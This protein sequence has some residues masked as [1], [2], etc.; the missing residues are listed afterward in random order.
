MEEAEEIRDDGQVDELFSYEEVVDGFVERV[1]GSRSGQ[2]GSGEVQSRRGGEAGAAGGA[3]EGVGGRRQAA[4]E[5]ADVVRQE[6]LVVL[7]ASGTEIVLVRL[8]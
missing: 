7:V 3:G 8:G 1:E 4:A 6:E 2:Q 5:R